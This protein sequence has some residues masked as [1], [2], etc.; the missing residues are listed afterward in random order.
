[1]RHCID[2]IKTVLK[3]YFT[4]NDGG[5][6]QRRCDYELVQMNDKRSKAS[7]AGIS[8]GI[9]R[10]AKVCANSGGEHSAADERAINSRSAEV[11]L[12]TPTPT[13]IPIEIESAEPQSDSTPIVISIP[14]VDKTE[15]H[16]YQSQVD[17]WVLAFPGIDVGQ[18]L[19]NIQQWCIA[20]QNRRKTR[21]GINAFI[22]R[23]LTSTQ[24]KAPAKQVTFAQQAFDIARTTV[25][26]SMGPDPALLKIEEDR[27]RA[28][29]MPDHIRESIKALTRKKM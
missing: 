2:E 5:W 8:S 10:R 14:L 13:P 15:H 9:A 16:V 25:P 20:N 11:E 17:G 6:H 18:Q 12:P 1:M 3:E 24:D 28:A 21:R 29:P 4:L 27:K 7:A 26:A 19:R 22:V 23:W